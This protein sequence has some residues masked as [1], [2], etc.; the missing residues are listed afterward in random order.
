M[1]IGFLS[2]VQDKVQ[3]PLCLNVSFNVNGNT[4]L[5]ETSSGWAVIYKSWRPALGIVLLGNMDG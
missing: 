3:R 1:E 4:L 5:I 2:P